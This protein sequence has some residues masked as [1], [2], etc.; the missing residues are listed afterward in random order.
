M[1]PGS[2][3][4]DAGLIHGDVIHGLDGA[5]IKSVEGLAQAVKALKA[6]DYLIEVERN[7]RTV[8]LTVTIE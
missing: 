6:G 5:E 3:A 2:V 1:Q 8:F 4:A 7:R